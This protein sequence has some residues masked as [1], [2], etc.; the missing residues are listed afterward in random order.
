M[1]S[2]KPVGFTAVYTISRV[3]GFRIYRLACGH[4]LDGVDDGATM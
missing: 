4:L 1:K 2:M 3:R